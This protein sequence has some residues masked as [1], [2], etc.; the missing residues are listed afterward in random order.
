M[1]TSKFTVGLCRCFSIG[2]TI[3]SPALN[4]CSVELA[5]ACFVFRFWSRGQTLFSAHNYWNG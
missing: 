4:G 1:K 3:H 2:V 5:V